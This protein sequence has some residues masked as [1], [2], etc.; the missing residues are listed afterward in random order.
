MRLADNNVH[1]DMGRP[2]CYNAAV[3][4]NSDRMKGSNV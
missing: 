3:E 4:I 1:L 2:V